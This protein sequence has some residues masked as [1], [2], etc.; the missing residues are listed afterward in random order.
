MFFD[1]VGIDVE[2]VIV[3]TVSIDDTYAPFR[4]T[5]PRS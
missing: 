2:W 3:R 1:V 4:V 5:T